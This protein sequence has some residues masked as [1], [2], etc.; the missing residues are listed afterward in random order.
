MQN[1]K[2]D[3]WKICVRKKGRHF[4][5]HFQLSRFRHSPDQFLAT[6]AFSPSE[7]TLAYKYFGLHSSSAGATVHDGLRPPL[8]LLAIGPDPVTFVYI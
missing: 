7:Y 8:R 6:A 2:E 1:H 5:I 4:P 3:I